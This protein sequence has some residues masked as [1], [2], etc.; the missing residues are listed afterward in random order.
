MLQRWCRHFNPRSP[1]GERPRPQVLPRRHG[2]FQSTLPVGGATA[3]TCHFRIL[4]SISIHAPRGGSD[5]RFGMVTVPPSY[6]NPRSPWGERPSNYYFFTVAQK[7]QSTLPVGGAT[8]FVIGEILLYEFQSTLPVGGATAEGAATRALLQISIH[9]PRG[10]SDIFRHLQ[11]GLPSSFQ[12]T[13]PVG[14]ATQRVYR[15][16]TVKN[17]SI[18]APRGGSDDAAQ[19]SRLDSLISIHAPRGGSDS[20]QA[21]AEKAAADFNPRSPWGERPY[22]AAVVSPSIS[23]QS[24]LPVGG[25]TP[26]A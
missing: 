15:C 19:N 11:S 4:L 8:L 14:G 25:A 10:G 7:F 12:S 5:V 18:H 17:I 13:L 3:I 21:A 2:R 9:A 1:W 20:D 24:T 16:I 23:F 26:A 22:L 6:F